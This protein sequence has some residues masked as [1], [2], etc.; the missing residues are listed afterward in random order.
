MNR[1]ISFTREL[2]FKISDFQFKGKTDKNHGTNL[3][4][5]I[6][7]I[8]GIAFSLNKISGHSLHSIT[9][10]CQFS[11]FLYGRHTQVGLSVLQLEM[12][13]PSLLTLGFCHKRVYLKKK[14]IYERLNDI[15]YDFLS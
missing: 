14:K 15:S 7:R 5:K 8:A 13:I 12:F 3:T 10:F 2:Q 1:P 11:S 9:P 6:E 4:S